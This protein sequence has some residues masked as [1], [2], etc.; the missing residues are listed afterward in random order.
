MVPR[1]RT[2]RGACA[3]G[4]V[5]RWQGAVASSSSAAALP[6][7]LLFPSSDQV[8]VIEVSHSDIGYIGLKNDI[9]V[10]ALQ[11]ADALAMIPKARDGILRGLLLNSLASGR[12]GAAPLEQVKRLVSGIAS[13]AGVSKARAGSAVRLALALSRRGGGGGDVAP[14]T[15]AWQHECIVILRA[16]LS[17]FPSL[18]S[19]LVDALE[20]GAFDVG[21]T[22][23]EP[24]ES[25]L[26]NELLAR[27]MYTGRLWAVDRYR[28]NPKVD[29]AVVVFHQDGPLRSTQMPQVYAKAG[30]RYLKSS[31]SVDGLFRW[32]SPDGTSLLALTEVHYCDNAF[33]SNSDFP[34]VSLHLL[35]LA[36]S[37]K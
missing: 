4:A 33:P 16:F 3:A 29:T 35:P 2:L 25:T 28:N 34:G 14:P 11:I 19:D 21:G 5:P 7:S 37:T 15:F 30:M 22:F 24:F 8:A 26:L 36:D 18:E 32:A 27:Q 10:D 23:S 12:H 6:T 1:P 20:A 9:L 17:M 13:A 31:R